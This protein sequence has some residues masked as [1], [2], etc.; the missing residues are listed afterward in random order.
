MSLN[1]NQKNYRLAN[2]AVNPLPQ[3]PYPD[4]DENRACVENRIDMAEFGVS[5]NSREWRTN[6]E[7]TYQF[8]LVL[9]IT[10]QHELYAVCISNKGSGGESLSV[11][12]TDTWHS[13]VHSHQFYIDT[14]DA[15]REVEEELFGGKK[16]RDSQRAVNS[17]YKRHYNSFIYNPFSYL[18][19]WEAG[20]Q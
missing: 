7:L 9:R 17:A 15:D 8:A 4:P 13:S 18:Q 6:D 19:R 20:K 1:R 10:E 3:D 14:I 2:L 11:R 5:V 16:E 12:R